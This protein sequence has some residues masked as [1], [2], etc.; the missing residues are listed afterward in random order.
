MGDI[1][2]EHQS[3][4]L[5][6]ID[7][8][9]Q[10][11]LITVIVACY[12]IEEYIK[13]CIDSITAQTYKNLEILITDD[14]STDSSGDICDQLASEDTRI[15]VFHTDNHGLGL[16]RDYAMDRA[17]GV[18]ITFVDGDDYIEPRMYEEMMAAMRAFDSDIV[19]SGY[20][21]VYEQ[22]RD[23]TVRESGTSSN[24]DLD[25]ETDNAGIA[26]GYITDL[27]LMDSQ[28]LLRA[29]VE[30]D[31]KYEVQ[32]CAWNKLYKKSL[33][34][35]ADKLRFPEGLYEDIV[36]TTKLLN[37]ASKGVVICD[38][39]YNYIIDR[40]GSIMNQG[41]K[42]DILTHQIPAYRK[43]DQVLCQAGY[44][45][46]AY[47][48]QY[49]VYKKLLLLYTQVRRTHDPDK[50][51][52]MSALYDVI[53]GAKNNYKNIYS[54]RIAD[55]HQELRMK[56]FLKNTILYNAFMAVNDTLII[57]VKVWI[58]KMIK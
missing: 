24:C 45:E 11:D 38:K 27:A 2:Q 15:K 33:V 48:H 50:K 16:A 35:D 36:Y 25:N 26:G 28:E 32:N 5:N 1:M 53:I 4:K 52:K 39:L 43:R 9:D 46:L 14:G 8:P 18:F 21:R 42:W 20:R 41:V 7:E 58:N 37:R 34:D 57:P 23:M 19:V 12:N 3:Y 51:A 47:T 40:S 55:P 6:R 49:M 30:E 22:T 54:C 44:R 13:R 29:L 10:T 56:L 17:N 31:E